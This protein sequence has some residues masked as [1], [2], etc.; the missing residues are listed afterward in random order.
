M[1][2]FLTGVCALLITGV[3]A[4]A[5]EKTDMVMEHN[6]AATPSQKSYQA[7]MDN[8]HHDMMAALQARDPD[9]AFALGMTAHHQGAIDM[10]KT[11]LKYGKDPEMRALA[12]A[13]IK[14]Q[15]PEI[16]RMQNWLK[17]QKK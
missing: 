6:N 2:K 3:T 12:E 17:Q 9:V 13:I 14:A 15:Q 10:A 5:A 7:G 8:M 4:Q 1:K 16:D 11:E